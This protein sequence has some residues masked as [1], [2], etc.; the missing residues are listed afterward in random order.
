MLT[1]SQTGIGDTTQLLWLQESLEQHVSTWGPANPGLQSEGAP[2]LPIQVFCSIWGCSKQNKNIASLSAMPPTL[3]QKETQS[4][5]N[6]HAELILRHYLRKRVLWTSNL[7]CIWTKLYKKDNKYILILW[8]NMGDLL[9]RV[10]WRVEL[11]VM[12]WSKFATLVWLPDLLAG[13]YCDVG[14]DDD[15][16]RWWWSWKTQTEKQKSLL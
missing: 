10:M 13:T 12:R 4:N 1:I 9:S 11:K 2:S 5:A 3:W 7:V 14:N 8:Q 15:D 6:I 16:G